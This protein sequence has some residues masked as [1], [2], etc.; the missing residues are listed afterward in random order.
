MKAR[1]VRWLAAGLSVAVMT[2]GLSGRPAAADEP[3]VGLPAQ[4]DRSVGGVELAPGAPSAPQVPSAPSYPAP[5]WPAAGSVAS[6]DLPASGA[7]GVTPLRAGGLP[8]LLGRPASKSQAAAA[9]YRIE[10][11][12]A[13]AVS[14]ST[15]P[16]VFQVSRTAG[17]TG[18]AGTTGVTVTVDT[19]GFQNA[20]GGDWSQRLHL[21][22][23]PEC[24]L[25]TPEADGCQP[26]ALPSRALGGRLTAEVEVPALTAEATG[27]AAQPAAT[28]GTG[29]LAVE[30]GASGT[31]GSFAASPLA[32]SSTWSGG[33]SSGDFT[34]SYPLR[35]PPA[36]GGPAPSLALQYSAQSVDGRTA[37]S[38]NQPSWAGEGF[39]FSPGGFIERRY[40]GC[41]DDMGADASNTT[42]TGDLCWVT[43]NAVFS[44]NGRASELLYD[45]GEKRWHLRAD[46]GTR[47]ERR[48]GAP[49]GAR[50]GEWWVA[51]AT[52]GTEYWF[53]RNQLPGW[54]S[55]KPETKSTL[56]TVVFGNHPG[57]PCATGTFATSSCTQAWRWNLDYVVDPNGN[58]MS[59]W[60]A[61]D[62]N[63][64]A[65]RL[66]ASD[67]VAYDR[68]G[69]LVRIDYGTRSDTAYGTAPVQVLLGTADRCLSACA[70]R[71][72]A[73][74]PDTPWDLDCTGTN[75]CAVSPNYWTSK[76]LASVTTRV[77]SG[78]A[79]TNVDA[80][81]FTHSY[82]DPGDGT[83]AGLWLASIGHSGLVG[84]SASVPTVQL[85]PEQLPNRVDT[86]DHSPPMD[87]SRL[88]KIRSET[89]AET[90]VTY[91]APDCV[92]GSR[93]P[94]SPQGNTLRCFPVY[95]T[96]E[97]FTDAV[98]DWFHKYVVKEVIDTDTTGKIPAAGPV[99]GYTPTLVTRYDYPDPPAWHYTDDDG[100]VVDKYKTWSEWRGYG[101]VRTTVGDPGQ[102]TLTETRYFR[103]MNGDHLPTGTRSV[104]VID[105]QGG[106]WPDDDQLAGMTREE[107][108]YNGPTGAEVSGTISDPWTSAP[109]ATRTI[110]GVTVTARFVE[111]AVS[112]D[113]T[114]LDGGRAP[115]RSRVTTTFD[116]LGMPVKVD[117]EGD[118][119]VS[120]DEAC[121]ATTYEPR[122]SDKWI[123]DRVQRVQTFALRCA[124]TADQSKL[125]ADDLMGDVR[126]SYDGQAFGLAPTAGNATR[127][128]ELSGW[129]AGAPSY[130]RTN[131][132]TYDAQGRVTA[133]LDAK[134]GST[135][136]VYTPATG[137][138]LTQ[139]TVTNPLGFVTTTTFQPAW[140]TSTTTVD[141]NG[142]VT[143]LAYDPLGRLTG[144][145]LPGRN[146]SAGQSA[147]A[148]YAYTVRDTGVSS[149]ATSKLA[150]NGGYVTS[151][152]LY[153][154][155]LRMRQSQSPEGGTSG[156][157]VVSDTLYDAAGRQLKS[158]GPYV[159]DGAAASTLYAPNQAI[160]AETRTVYDGAG[161]TTATIFLSN[162]F[163]KW[164]GTAAFGGDRTD[165]TPPPGGTA[166]S[167]FTDARGHTTALRQYHAAT[168]TGAYDQTTYTYDRKGLLSRVTDAAG[169]HWDYGYDLRA[170]QTR[171]DHPDKGTTT[172]TYN[173]AGELTST[174]DARGEVLVSTYDA[175]GRK[176]AL[177]DDSESSANLRAQ[178]VYD[179]VAKG[180][181]SSTTR[182]VR[183]PGV[184]TPDQYTSRITARDAA[185][186][187]TTTEVVVP[188][189]QGALAG[190]YTYRT[191]YKV[192]G[193]PAIT[194]LPAAGG[195]PAETLS[196]DYN[197]LGLV[198]GMRTTLGATYVTG[199]SYTRFGELNVVN[200]RN[201]AG[202]SF[203]QGL[204]YQEGTRRLDHAESLRETAPTKVADPHY[205]WDP[206]GNV[207]AIS[208]P[209]TGDNQCFR[210]DYLL[211][212]KK[213]WTPANGD[214]G[215][216]PTAAAL[217]GPAKYW[218]SW[219]Y[220]LTGN[221]T[222]QVDHATAS[223]DVT[224]NYSYP[225]PGSARPHTLSSAGAATYGYD[226][227]G[228]TAT[229]PSPGG[230]TQSLTW[231]AEGHLASVTDGGQTSEY[232]YDVDGTRLLRKEAAGTTLYL[233]G[234]DLRLAGGQVTATR[235]YAYDGKTVAQRN[236]AGLTW[237]ADDRQ[238]T[239]QV[240]VAAVGQALTARH[241]TPFGA[242]RGA[243]VTWPNDRG[244]TGG[245]KEPS[246][247]THLGAREY[248]PTAGRFVSADQVVDYDDPQQANG[249]AYANSSP[250]TLSDADGLYREMPEKCIDVC[251]P[252]S[253]K[254]QPAKQAQ[255]ERC[256]STHSANECNPPS[257]RPS[258]V[259]K[260]VTYPNH[261]VLIIHYDGTASV[262]GY[263]LPGHLSEDQ[264]DRI[265][266]RM[267]EM[268][269]D[270]H[271]GASPDLRQTLT[272]A[273]STCLEPNLGY[274]RCGDMAA[275]VADDRHAL[276]G[277]P[278]YTFAFCAGGS[279]GYI[280]I[281]VVGTVC[282]ANSDDGIGFYE[283]YGGGLGKEGNGRK[284][285]GALYA[286]PAISNQGL[287][288]QAGASSAVEGS[289]RVAGIGIDGAYAENNKG[290]WNLGLYTGLG[291]GGGFMSGDAGTCVQRLYP[292][293]MMSCH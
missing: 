84:G 158:Y 193:S 43:D 176:T 242:P 196:Y 63:R 12:D 113:R 200:Y 247:L 13:T 151:Y 109:T 130:V 173:E 230:G 216:D 127:T 231:D 286:G 220:D 277:P 129:N 2:I 14:R 249:Y 10:L 273:E 19:S 11:L 57:E 100:L 53:G 285:G 135:T 150:P 274:D 110:D 199:T 80:W 77:W 269:G 52:D 70:T 186:R 157:R 27:D 115:R 170:Q 50:N 28:T 21:V 189:A 34:W 124:Q 32:P 211:R 54:T 134:G 152:A 278:S 91:S 203:Q 206:V 171:F 202:P 276:D 82:P 88:H 123:L 49:N 47:V 145:W 122:N 20:F 94:S 268:W 131:Q 188:P 69:Y 132:L 260:T 98:L 23:L 133:S 218:Q 136:T 155:L 256:T 96:P 289:G 159:A 121:T 175:L 76:R 214:C 59:F 108:T 183:R 195:L 46:D 44:L 24:A 148:T 246:G 245:T 288:D 81:T 212:L 125:T 72:K 99:P 291:I 248:D 18:G 184:T 141:P 9:S 244:L 40:K 33:G 240:A 42:R 167:T 207:T 279:L 225:A 264:A 7:A 107:I 257:P 253:Q 227:A 235:W 179:T 166:T 1:L 101:R 31:D 15:R 259:K 41:A 255:E 178:W 209:V 266:Q 142:K 147:N 290:V 139:T 65:R 213:A 281:G 261:T 37:A 8:V 292:H 87:W 86:I 161:R 143:D 74:W 228:E 62:T 287:E 103:G 251:G 181:L 177:Y 198:Q 282:F 208:D 263:I 67:K 191:G 5:A 3:F 106:S 165:V 22:E 194:V 66:T 238:G 226:L 60:Y 275:K 215:P 156:G 229:R 267:D 185:Y 293:P 180:Q 270:G 39:D 75:P 26:S 56:N 116:S 137:G 48:T 243:A 119:G 73:H 258:D 201:N 154:S 4:V 233:P 239:G 192:D 126:T 223:G 204:Y 187:P 93:M 140:G 118:L 144:V 153:D 163:E 262:N 104:S 111:V 252:A 16:M 83:R 128:E 162:G 160:P 45:A 25:R 217:G 224:T 71:D 210:Y 17:A 105:S 64:Y 237:L 205:T 114:D 89:G 254:K 90:T 68:G 78:T 149:V 280:F 61:K 112:N 58:T 120:G 265:A 169:N 95:W 284:L 172:S 271:V 241:Q 250:V 234:M 190:T 35:V 79:Y 146:R 6:V 92:A 272:L 222:Q 197:A 29:L 97:G 182:F 38:N 232:L 219:D 138:P 55:G 30:A 36:V 164:R 117:D 102:Q 174:K 85:F 168:P 51:T 236:Q 221:R 283:T